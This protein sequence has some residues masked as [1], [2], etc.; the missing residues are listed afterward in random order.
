VDKPAILVHLRDTLP[1]AFEALKTFVPEDSYS[2]PLRGIDEVPRGDFA[3]DRELAAFSLRKIQLLFTLAEPSV[4]T[5]SDVVIGLCAEL[6]RAFLQLAETASSRARQ[7]LEHAIADLQGCAITILQL[8]T[9]PG[10]II[11]LE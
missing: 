2:F 6:V 5:T 10:T 9:E 1:A 7:T 3:K 8:S 11:S 4:P